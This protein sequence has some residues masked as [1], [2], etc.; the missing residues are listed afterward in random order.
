MRGEGRP[1][2]S[3]WFWTKFRRRLCWPTCYHLEHQ[4]RQLEGRGV[5]GEE[6][7]R[8]ARLKFGGLE[9]VKTNAGKRTVYPLSKPRFR[10]FGTP[11]EP[12]DEAR[13][14]PQSGSGLL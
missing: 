13:R 7:Q 3:P 9:Q 8:E 14:S 12:G 11:S 4:H 6:A 2:P 10:M 5:T 1:P